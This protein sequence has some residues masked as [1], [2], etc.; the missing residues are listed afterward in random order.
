MIKQELLS[1]KTGTK[2]HD[3]YLMVP[4]VSDELYKYISF[5]DYKTN[6]DVKLNDNGAI[7]T[8]KMAKLLDAKVGDNIKVRD[9][10][11]QLYFVKV[12]NIV[13]NYTYHYIYMTN[14]YYEKVFDKDITYNTIVANTDKNI[15]QTK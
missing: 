7:I 3:V 15:N 1:F 4:K 6:E 13:K 2:K 5:K 11:N 9:N 8:E 12:S 10:N 14:S